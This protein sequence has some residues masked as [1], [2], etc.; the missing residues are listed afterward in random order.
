MTSYRCFFSDAFDRMT[1]NLGILYLENIW[2]YF[3][4]VGVFMGAGMM[5]FFFVFL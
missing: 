3:E 1:Q 2:L 5:I 4:T